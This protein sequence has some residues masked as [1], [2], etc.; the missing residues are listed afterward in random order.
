MIRFHGNEF[1]EEILHL[2]NWMAEEILGARLAKTVSISII[3]KDIKFD[4]AEEAIRKDRRYF[5]SCE[6][7]DTRKFRFLL[8]SVLNRTPIRAARSIAHEMTHVKQYVKEE[9][10]DYVRT[11]HIRWKGRKYRNDITNCRTRAEYYKIPWEKEAK[12]NEIL[13][14]KYFRQFPR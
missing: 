9:L 8:S 6:R 12:T 5:G 4:K 10:Y 13:F 1:R 14:R 11:P 2:S 7:V 3:W